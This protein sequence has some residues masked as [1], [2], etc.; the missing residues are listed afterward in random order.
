[1]ADAGVEARDLG[2]EIMARRVPHLPGRRRRGRPRHS[3]AELLRRVFLIDVLVCPRCGGVRRLLAAIHDP[4]SIRRVLGSMGL[5]AEV[6]VLACPRKG[7]E[8]KKVLRKAHA[9]AS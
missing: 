8:P 7:T 1:M 2:R 9:F 6:P 5:V 4:E 3:W